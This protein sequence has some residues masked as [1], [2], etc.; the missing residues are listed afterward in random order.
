MSRSPSSS[1][2]SSNPPP[3][4]SNRAS[5][6]TLRLRGHAEYA[7][8]PFWYQ[9]T[10]ALTGV[11]GQEQLVSMTSEVKHPFEVE[12]EVNEKD[13]GERS[14]SRYNYYNVFN[15]RFHFSDPNL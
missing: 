5:R 3:L 10:V 14:S 11:F 13:R 15:V 2:A 6:S 7:A 8:A 1:P 4:P 9:Q 12:V